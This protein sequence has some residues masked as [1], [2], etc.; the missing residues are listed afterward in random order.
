MEDG[1]NMNKKSQAES[2]IIFFVLMI[3]VFITSIIVLRMTNAVITPFQNQIGNMSAPAGAAVEYAH[4]RFTQWW[5][6]GIVLLFFLSVIMLL[7][8]SFLVDIHPA[9]LLIYIICVILMFVFGNYGL[10]ALDSVWAAMG[11]DVETSQT[12]LQ[13]FLI[14]HFSLIMLGVVILSGVIMYAKFKYFQGT[15]GGNY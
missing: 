12:G 15:P 6:Y 7:V 1:F 5:D 9:F 8:S 11:T 3:A 13:Q 2:I 4:S 10:Y 14:N